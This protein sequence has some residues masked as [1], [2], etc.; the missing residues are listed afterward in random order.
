MGGC[1]CG[2]RMNEEQTHTQ[3]RRTT[4]NISHSLT[5]LVVEKNRSLA[6]QYVGVRSDDD[7]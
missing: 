7:T 4:D 5:E 2:L 1:A 6:R 3:P